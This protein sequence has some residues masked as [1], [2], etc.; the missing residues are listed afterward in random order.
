MQTSVQKFW[1]DLERY[2]LVK[3]SN[4]ILNVPL[5]LLEEIFNKA[6]QFHN[7]N[8]VTNSEKPNL[9]EMPTSSQTISDEEIE[10]EISKRYM[11]P[12]QDYAW[13]DACK[14]YREKLIS[15]AHTNITRIKGQEYAP[16]SNEIQTAVEWLM[17]KLN[18]E[19]Y[20]HTMQQALEIEKK[21]I[22]DSCA[23]GNTFPEYQTDIDEIGKVYYK[24][25]Y[26]KDSDE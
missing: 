7:E 6:Q 3:D 18:L 10:E 13:R 2:G 4:F 12:T 23:Y 14:W 15:Q 1:K 19:G 25:T 17:K 20:D 16:T 26:K 11:H 22:I 9:L 24:W 5:Q 21:Q 8:Y